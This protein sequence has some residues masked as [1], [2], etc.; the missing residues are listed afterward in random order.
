MRHSS[1]GIALRRLA[2]VNECLLEIVTEMYD[3]QA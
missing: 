3:E 2:G 1:S